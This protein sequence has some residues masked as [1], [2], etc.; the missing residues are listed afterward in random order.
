MYFHA[1]SPPSQASR[2]RCHDEALYQVSLR[3]ELAPAP[4]APAHYPSVFEARQQKEPPLYIWAFRNA[5]PFHR[6]TLVLVKKH[7]RTIAQLCAALTR[8]IF[9]NG[10]VAYTHILDGELT[11]VV[12]VGDLVPNQ[13]YLACEGGG[14]CRERRALRW[15][16]EAV[17]LS[18]T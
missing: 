13:P 9:P 16:L 12:E 18:K 10:G 15:F 2:R 5:D 7:I 1:H 14:P 17:K 8:K 11:P 4:R 6:G 3:R